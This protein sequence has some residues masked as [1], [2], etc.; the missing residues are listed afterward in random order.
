ME[1]TTKFN[2]KSVKGAAYRVNVKRVQ[3]YENVDLYCDGDVITKPEYKEYSIVT[4]D[5]P[6]IGVSGEAAS[7]VDDGLS[8]SVRAG[9]KL[10]QVRIIALPCD[11]QAINDA[12]GEILDPAA[13]ARRDAAEEAEIR[14]E[15][16]YRRHSKMMSDAMTD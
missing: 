7:V 8:F 2:F 12:C 11:L 15:E 16:L 1:K 14:A 3:G 13:K 5:V 9:G 10:R 6:S 4:V